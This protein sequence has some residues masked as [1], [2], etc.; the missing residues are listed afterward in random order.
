M[1]LRFETKIV[2]DDDEFVGIE[3]EEWCGNYRVRFSDDKVTSVYM[4]L[5]T[6][7]QAVDIVKKFRGALDVMSGE[8]A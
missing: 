7:D 4:P 5:E 6:F 2:I 8:R 3:I 1:E